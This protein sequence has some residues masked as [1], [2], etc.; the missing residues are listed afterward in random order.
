MYPVFITIGKITIFNFSVFLVLAWLTFSFLFWRA[1]R[2]AGIE[3]DRI[4]DLTFYATIIAFISARTVFVAT[5]WELF[6]DT[7]LKIIAFWV[8]PGFSLYG[9]ILGGVAT[10]VSM[11]RTTKIRLGLVLDA[12]VEAIP[13]ALVV[14]FIGA[15]LDGTVV[16]KITDVPWALRIDGHVGLRHPIAL[17]TIA[18]LIVIVPI[19]LLFVRKATRDKKPYGVVGV[20]F[21]LLFSFVMFILELFIESRVYWS[22]TANQW[23]L[24]AIF[25]ESLGALFVRGGGREWVRPFVHK[26]YAKFSK[27]RTQ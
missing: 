1:L 17:Y 23:I 25:A 11:S 18:C 27:R 10:L 16:G 6:S 7:F 9:G 8:T 26:L 14:G 3:E 12:L 13:L 22:F 15:F 5:H 2:R 4:F 20:W 19:H 24:I 21:F